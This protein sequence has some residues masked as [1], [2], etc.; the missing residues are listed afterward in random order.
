MPGLD[1]FC[2]RNPYHEGAKVFGSQKRKPDTPIGIDKDSHRPNTIN[3]SRPRPPKRVTKSHA[4]TLLTI[5][6]EVEGFAEQVHASPPSG[7][8]ICHIIAV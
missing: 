2:T 4:N 5:I 7:I 1:E 6:E 3:F 8:D